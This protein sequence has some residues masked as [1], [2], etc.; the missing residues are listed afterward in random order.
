VPRWFKTN[1]IPFDKMWSDDKHWLPL[2]LQ[3]KHINAAFT[4]LED[5]ETFDETKIILDAE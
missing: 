2:A 1:A 4:F 5:N 3:G